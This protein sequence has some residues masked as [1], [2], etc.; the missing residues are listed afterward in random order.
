MLITAGP[1]F[2]IISFYAYFLRLYLLFWS[3][4]YQ[5]QAIDFLLEL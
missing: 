3:L 1:L 2:Q 4:Q 5:G